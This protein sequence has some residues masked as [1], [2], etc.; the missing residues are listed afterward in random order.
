[1]SLKGGRGEGRGRQ[2]NPAS[3]QQ[4]SSSVVL[5][6]MW[7]SDLTPVHL[8]MA[9]LASGHCLRTPIEAY[10][11]NRTIEFEPCYPLPVL[12]AFWC[13]ERHRPFNTLVYCD[14]RQDNGVRVLTIHSNKP[15]LCWRWNRQEE[16]AFLPEI[17]QLKPG[18]L[19]APT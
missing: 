19:P 14:R 11:E 12:P 3:A 18:S 13:K 1:M 6:V 15:S 16:K 10:P 7:Y 17:Q 9:P 2:N 8:G 4:Y 5:V